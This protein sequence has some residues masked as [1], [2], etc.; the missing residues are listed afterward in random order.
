MTID[1]RKHLHLLQ[2][3]PQEAP[4]GV[5]EVITTWSREFN[6][7]LVSPIMDRLQ[8]PHFACRYTTWREIHRALLFRC[9][10][11]QYYEPCDSDESPYLK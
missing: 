3:S 4:T 8:P 5:G 6:K 9:Y 10:R 11:H 7:I 2:R 1:F